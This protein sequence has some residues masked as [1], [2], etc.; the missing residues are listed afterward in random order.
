MSYITTQGFDVVGGITFVAPAHDSLEAL[1]VEDLQVAAPIAQ[2]ADYRQHSH[3]HGL[4]NCAALNQLSLRPLL[5]D[6]ISVISFNTL[7]L[8]PPIGRSGVLTSQDVGSEP[9][10]NPAK[11][12]D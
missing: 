9:H 12:C 1:A 3:G 5:R 10:S 2:V 4:V 7:P 8:R 6:R 11:P